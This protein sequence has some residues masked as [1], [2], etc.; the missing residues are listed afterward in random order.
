MA[1]IFTSSVDNK[2]LMIGGAPTLSDAKG[3]VGPFPRYSISREEIATGDGT[4]I[5]SKY[6]INVT[7][8]ATINK[9][10]SQDMM[11]LGER[12]NRVQGEAIKALNFNRQEFPKLCEGKLEIE[13]YGGGGNAIAFKDARLTGVELPEQNEDTAGVQN[14]EYSFTFEAYQNDS[15]GGNTGDFGDS[16]TPPYLLSS[17][18]ENW[19]FS[20]N[21]GQ[22]VFLSASGAINKTWILTHTV[23]GTGKKSFAGSN[24]EGDGEAWRQASQ[25]VQSRVRDTKAGLVD[26]DI[27]NNEDLD[28]KFQPLCMDK[29][30]EIGLILVDLVETHT[31]YNHARTISS[32]QGAGTYSVTD[33]WLV[34]ISAA[35]A[36]AE[37]DI[38]E[39]IDQ[40]ASAVIVTVSG[41]IQGISTGGAA[42][43]ID[44][45][46]DNAEAMLGIFLAGAELFDLASGSYTGPEA[47]INVRKTKNI[48]K[49]KAAGSITFSVS[50]DDQE[51][52][53]EGAIKE[54]V[55]ISY[56]NYAV[57]GIQ[58]Q[59]VAIIGVLNKLDG[60]VIQDMG[61][62][63]EMKLSVSADITM[64][65]DFR[66]A[67]PDGT[68]FLLIVAPEIFS[69][70]SKRQS[71]SE[72]WDPFTGVYNL[73]LS[74]VLDG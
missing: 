22:A 5:N 12:Q 54:G 43:L 72:T 51:L 59:K 63:D 41:T 64:G 31:V 15:T 17:A 47:L 9:S 48:S 38:T 14:L 3:Y 10:D 21:D 39:D 42:D 29:E 56:D 53:T 27:M 7:G 25:Y 24:L 73:S 8:T 45:R 34:A 44:D 35:M 58:N 62:T 28:A 18:E 67:K 4:F 50:Y 30:D 49:S 65:M 20:P 33:T 23:S 74:I 52:I 6:T 19:D 32:D 66:D 11:T 69:G 71:T 36:T 70:D 26:G 60:P 57:N 40:S 61:T 16:A 46:F 1:I 68:A 2:K 55:T 37:F 13:P